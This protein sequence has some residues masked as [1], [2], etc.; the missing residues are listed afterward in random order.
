M[1]LH[2]QLV[3]PDQPTSNKQDVMDANKKIL[4]IIDPM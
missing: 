4:K 2:C 3:L 1:R